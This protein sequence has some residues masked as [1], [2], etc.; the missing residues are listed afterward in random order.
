MPL[1]FQFQGQRSRSP[2]PLMLTHIVCHIFRTTR[3]TDFKLGVQMEDDD[4]HQPQVLFDL[5]GQR[6]RSQGHVISLSCLGPMLYLCH[7]RLLGAYHVGRTLRPHFLFFLWVIAA[8]AFDPIMAEADCVRSYRYE[9]IEISVLNLLFY[10]LYVYA[11]NTCKN[12]A[13]LKRLYF[14][15]KNS[16]HIFVNA[17][18]QVR[19]FSH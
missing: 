9:F 5:Q 19:I 3:S 16:M 4:P 10:I 2:G 18:V 11:E 13:C 8:S 14:V 17:Y 6:S 1:E 12:V 15:L 7:L